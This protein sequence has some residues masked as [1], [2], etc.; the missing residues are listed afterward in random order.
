MFSCS[1]LYSAVPSDYQLSQAINMSLHAS[2]LLVTWVTQSQRGSFRAL[3]P[4][5]REIHESAAWSHDR[6]WT[7]FV[8]RVLAVIGWSNWEM[9]L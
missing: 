6:S 8:Q 2:D 9:G 3:K 7:K 1:S 4:R 5:R